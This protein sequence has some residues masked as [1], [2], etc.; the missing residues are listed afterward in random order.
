M[1]SDAVAA[2]SLSDPLDSHECL[3]FLL[4]ENQAF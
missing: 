4:I 3:P 1:N 2:A